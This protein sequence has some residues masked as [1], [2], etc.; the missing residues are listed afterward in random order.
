MEIQID[1]AGNRLLIDGHVAQGRRRWEAAALGLLLQGAHHCAQRACAGPALQAWLSERGQRNMLNRKQLSRLFDALAGLFDE[2]GRAPQFA[3]RFGHAPR[4]RTVGPWWWSVHAGDTVRFAEEPA[5]HRLRAALPCLTDDPDAMN[6]ARLCK[7]LLICQAHL[8]EG[9]CRNAIDGLSDLHAW[10]GASDELTA[11]RLLRLAEARVALREFAHARAAL[12]RLDTLLAASVV[13]RSH[14]SGAALML[15]HRLTYAETPLHSYAAIAEALAPMLSAPPGD[16]LLEVDGY[17][18]GAALNLAA[19][20][21]RRW[22]EEHAGTA[23][24]AE[25]QARSALAMRYACAALF[26]YAINYQYEY[27]QKTCS[28]LAYFTQTCH[29]LGLDVA[30]ALAFAWYALAQAWQDRFELPDNSVWECIFLGDF[31]LY[32]PAARGVFASH[33]LRSDWE[34]RRPDTLA[35]YVHAARRARELGD[36]RQLG[37]CALNL[38]HFTRLHGMRDEMLAAHAA[39]RRVL[40]DYPDI[41]ALLLAEGY[42]LS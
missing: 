14:F 28:N 7:Q 22:L 23:P 6:S 19:L 20:C 21:E 9:E 30:P 25:T 5:P 18:R 8:T 4:G 17:A 27:V 26:S 10:R 35:F 11:W 41:E 29:R 3:A 36:P 12:D 33:S 31:W 37:H 15:G 16:T 32:Q 42:S 39:L 38:Y 40:A 24:R 1:V 13:A 2:A 34:G